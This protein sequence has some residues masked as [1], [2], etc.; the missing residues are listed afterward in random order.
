MDSLDLQ[1]GESIKFLEDVVYVIV[2]LTFYPGKCIESLDTVLF[3]YSRPTNIQKKKTLLKNSD[4][5]F[6]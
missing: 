1:F 4:G 2:A 5:I 3:Y 6:C